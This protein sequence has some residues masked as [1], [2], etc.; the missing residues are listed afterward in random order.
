MTIIA[1]KI[2]S[3]DP[4][5]LQNEVLSL[6]T[7]SHGLEVALYGYSLFKNNVAD[8][9]SKID[10]KI[11]HLWQKRVHLTGLL[12]YNRQVWSDLEFELSIAHSLGI[13]NAVIHPSPASISLDSNTNPVLFANSI[14][15]IIDNIYKRGLKLHIENTFQSLSFHREL[16]KQLYTI[17]VADKCGFCLD[18]GH[19]RVYN[20]NTLDEWL[21]LIKELKE[22]GFSQHYHIHVNDGSDDQ[23]RTLIDGHENGLLDPIPEWTPRGFIPWLK[24]AICSTPDAIFCME[25]PSQKAREALGYANLINL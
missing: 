3:N 24:D 18:T 8:E 21:D 20:G 19:V 25:H 22:M 14:A 2:F 15:P 12:E 23:H 6:V 9:I 11:I 7:K 10:R 17:G 5:Y 4:E 16:Y 1:P 13:Y